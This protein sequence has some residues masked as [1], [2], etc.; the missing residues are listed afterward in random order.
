MVGVEPLKCAH[1]V[2]FL[3]VAL[4]APTARTR[5]DNVV[6]ELPFSSH[7]CLQMPLNHLV[8]RWCSFVLR[9]LRLFPRGYPMF[10]LFSV[11]SLI[12]L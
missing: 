8:L 1:G 2:A 12:C 3:L 11:V 9:V 10:P 4:P 6:L 7:G 5:A